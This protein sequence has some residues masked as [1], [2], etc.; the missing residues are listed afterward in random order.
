MIEHNTPCRLFWFESANLA[1]CGH[2][3]ATSHSDVISKP[4]VGF[5]ALSVYCYTTLNSIWACW[6]YLPIRFQ[7]S[8]SKV[9]FKLKPFE[10]SW[11]R[12][13][14]YLARVPA[15]G[16]VHIYSKPQFRSWGTTRRRRQAQRVGEAI[17]SPKGWISR[18][19][20]CQCSP[21]LML[22]I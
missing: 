9:R 19:I 7:D 5:L 1:G 20:I 4:V 6:Y 2:K 12:L 16:S 17:V 13:T 22:Q 3:F 14:V 10:T 11:T 8:G 18:I 15:M 21:Y